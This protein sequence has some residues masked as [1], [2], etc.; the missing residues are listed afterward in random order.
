M[1]ADGHWLGDHLLGSDEGGP[2]GPAMPGAGPAN[3][4]ERRKAQQARRRR[5]KESY[6]VI[7]KRSLSPSSTQVLLKSLCLHRGN[8]IP[9]ARQ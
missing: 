9:P 8:V 6:A 2:T 5:E 4:V 7:V 1:T 3:A